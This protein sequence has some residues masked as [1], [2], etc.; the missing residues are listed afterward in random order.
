MRWLNFVR[1]QFSEDKE[2]IPSLS[3]LD[4]RIYLADI[5]LEGTL[6]EPR[7]I[8]VIENRG[9]GVAH[10]VYIPPIMFRSREITFIF[11]AGR[12]EVTAQG[13]LANLGVNQ[14]VDVLIDRE[15]AKSHKRDI[16]SLL[17]EECEAKARAEGGTML[18]D[19]SIPL[20]ISYKT[21]NKTKTLSTHITIHYNVRKRRL[22]GAG[23][24]G[25]FT[26]QGQ[27]IKQS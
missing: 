5:R 27:T 8:F 23:L 21:V 13:W 17:D 20:L 10:D 4:P 9:G 11:L 22:R 24:D 25:L 12:S 1:R 14:K 16:I 3:D 18:G 19:F 2:T 26:F 15:N 7:T 6:I